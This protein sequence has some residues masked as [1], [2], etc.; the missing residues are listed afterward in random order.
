M[1]YR[2][3]RDAQENT[4][5]NKYTLKQNCQSRLLGYYFDDLGA[6]QQIKYFRNDC[7]VMAEVLI[8]RNEQ[9]VTNHSVTHVTTNLT[10]IGCAPVFI[11]NDE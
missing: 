1:D 10:T 4:T 6:E 5:I 3:I 2:I 8:R 7:N 11:E 9:F